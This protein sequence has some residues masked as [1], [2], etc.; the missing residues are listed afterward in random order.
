MSSRIGFG[1]FRSC[2]RPV[3]SRSPDTARTPIAHSRRAGFRG[4]LAK[5]VEIETLDSLIRKAGAR[6]QLSCL[7]FHRRAASTRQ[8]RG[9]VCVSIFGN[10]QI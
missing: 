10:T 6:T 8:L 4:A 2:T 7:S 3:S 5:P 9:Y 1:R